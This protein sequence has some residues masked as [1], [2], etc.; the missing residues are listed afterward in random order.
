MHRDGIDH[1]K[2]SRSKLCRLSRRASCLF[3]YV[4]FTCR[5]MPLQPASPAECGRTWQGPPV[6]I[7]KSIASRCS[8]VW[9]SH[10]GLYADQLAADQVCS[11]RPRPCACLLGRAFGSAVARQKLST[12]NPRY[13]GARRT[14]SK[15]FSAATKKNERVTTPSARPF[16]ISIFQSLPQSESRRG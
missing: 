13:A 16:Q 15:R 9:V 3:R 14:R 11:R 6:H 12:D 4:T 1:G 10:M 8:G 2:R 7:A 5:H